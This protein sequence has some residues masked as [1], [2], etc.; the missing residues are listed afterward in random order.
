MKKNFILFALMVFLPVLAFAQSVSLNNLDPAGPVTYNGADQKPTMS[1]TTSGLSSNNYRNVS[2]KYQYR[3]RANNYSNW[4]NWTDVGDNTEFVEVGQYQIQ[5][6]VSYE[7]RYQQN[8]YPG[9]ITSSNNNRKTFTI[10]RAQVYMSGLVASFD[11]ASASYTGSEIDEP[12]VTVTYDLNYTPQASESPRAPAINNNVVTFG[13]DDFSISWTK[14]GVAASLQEPGDYT[15]VI[16]F[17]ANSNFNFVDDRG[18]TVNNRRLTANEAFTI[19]PQDISSMNAANVEYVNALTYNGAAQDPSSVSPFV[20]KDLQNNVM[21][22]GTDY[23]V[24]RVSGGNFMNVGTY[25]FKIVGKGDKYTG[26]TGE[27]TYTIGRKYLK[28][29]PGQVTKIYGEADPE[30]YFV[31]EGI[32]KLAR[33][34]DR[35]ILASQ[36]LVFNRATVSGVLDEGEN[37]GDHYYYITKAA[38]MSGCDYEIDIENNTSILVIQPAKLYVHVAQNSK[39]YSGDPTT[40][41]QDFTADKKVGTSTQ[42]FTIA[43]A[44]GEVITTNDVPAGQPRK[45]AKDYVDQTK[46]LKDV[47]NIGRNPGEDVG[48]YKFTYDN[49]N[50]D[51]E[52]DGKFAIGPANVPDG[53]VVN[54]SAPT[55]DGTAKTPT[56]WGVIY[57]G[58]WLQEGIDWRVVGYSNNTNAGDQA[59]LTLEFINNFSGTKQYTF[60]I[61]KR[62]LIVR[63]ESY[64]R[65]TGDAEPA[66]ELKYEGY[67]LAERDKDANGQPKISTVAPK[68]VIPNPAVIKKA[69]GFTGIYTLEVV[70]EGWITDN[71]TLYFQDGSLTYDAAILNITA[72]NKSKTYGSADPEFTVTVDWPAGVSESEKNRLLKPAGTLIY[73]LSREEGENVKADGYKISFKGPKAIEGYAINYVPGTLTINK[74]ALTITPDNQSKTYGEVDPEF[75]ATVT[76]LVQNAALGIDDTE[77]SVLSTTYTYSTPRGSISWTV[78]AYDVYC[79]DQQNRHNENVG[80]YQIN[81]I[82][83]PEVANYTITYANPNGDQ[84]K[85]GWLTINKRP[86]VITAKDLEKYYGQVDPALTVSYSKETHKSADDPTAKEEGLMSSQV[87]DH[88]E[89]QGWN[90][91]EVYRTVYDEINGAAF[92]IERSRPDNTRNG[93]NVG[94]YDIKITRLDCVWRNNQYIDYNPNY[95]IT[96]VNGKLTIN[97]AELNVVALDQAIKY[98]KDINDSYVELA[99]GTRQYA[100]EWS[101]VKDEEGNPKGGITTDNG[102]KNDRVI[103]A[104]WQTWNETLNDQIEQIIKLKAKYSN[105]GYH[106]KGLDYDVVEPIGN[107][108]KINFTSAYL[109]VGALKTIP[110][111][112]K[113][114]QKMYPDV[115]KKYPE[116]TLAQVLDDHQGATVDVVMN[117][118]REFIADTWYTLVLPFD[119]RVRDLSSALGYA[120]ADIYNEA[121]TKANDMYLKL[122]VGTLEANKPFVVKVDKTIPAGNRKAGDNT[123]ERYMNE[124]TFADVVIAPLKYSTVDPSVTD[125]AGNQF[126]GTYKA[127]DD[128]DATQW[129]IP[130]GMNDFYHGGDPDNKWP[131]VQTE[132]YWVGSNAAAPVRLFIEEPDGSITAIGEVEAEVEAEAA[133]GWYSVTGIKLDAEPTAP[134]TYIFNGKK[135]Y[136]K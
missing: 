104:R 7:V 15:P 8:W 127:I 63:A 125:A 93:E 66:F 1:C 59:K 89:W 25:T 37:V 47:L 118:K 105:V 94:E 34:E 100:Y 42:Y 108:Y 67:G 97:P 79:I 99:D 109:Y 44:A 119:I 81:A 123:T 87:F 86:L 10:Q 77:E 107:N 33:P 23:E 28:I 114:L 55:Y 135:V 53:V 54:V 18:Q 129:F 69:T 128:M 43:N 90:L 96:Y 57:Q 22:L 64:A 5:A 31:E 110:L 62:P 61:K 133:E 9:S 101:I 73:S 49:K 103:V 95:D 27:F 30:P 13:E 40:D 6:V 21:T 134:G 126:I 56:P 121:N 115:A 60:T 4:S 17:S 68:F 24:Q 39:V 80:K 131:L 3:Y 117:G 38:D 82:G 113:Q 76:G 26:E 58:V 91:V 136:I 48:Q 45:D 130:N 120:V 132:A 11:P 85:S 72:D 29:A 88:Y 70:Q 12:T 102:V 75:T 19:A 32:D 2:E 106:E 46:S 35:A 50:Y 84:K 111:N 98:G 112:D 52:F 71:Y 92:K 41:P 78:W 124:I 36:Y 116:N 65:T 74:K 14:D 20:V 16:T 122:H 51:V 83:Q